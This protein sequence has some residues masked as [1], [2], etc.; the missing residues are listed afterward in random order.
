MKLNIDRTITLSEVSLE[1]EILSDGNFGDVINQ[2]AFEVIDYI[3]QRTEGGLD[4]RGN[5]FEF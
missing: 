4:V 2:I 1:V 3:V 5:T